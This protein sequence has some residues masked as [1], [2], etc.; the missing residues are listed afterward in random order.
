MKNVYYLFLL[1]LLSCSEAESQVNKNYTFIFSDISR[2]VYADQNVEEKKTNALLSLL[3][4]H[5]VNSGDIVSVSYIHGATAQKG[6][7]FEFEFLPQT[8][9]SKGQS[10]LKERQ[11]RSELELLNRKYKS[12]F[13]TS[14]RNKCFGVEKEHDVTSVFGAFRVLS[15]QLREIDAE[16]NNAYFF[17]DLKQCDKVMRRL[18]CENGEKISTYDEALRLAKE[19]LPKLLKHYHLDEKCLSTLDE[20]V[21]VL[22]SNPLVQADIAYET[23]PVYFKYLFECMGVNKVTFK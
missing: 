1:T 10:N 7:L 18:F 16:N 13:A 5:V 12:E 8:Y 23:L 15:D 6:N 20:V 22:P 9:T 4:K 17:T 21:V 2:S 14:I 19:D 11:A 3:Q